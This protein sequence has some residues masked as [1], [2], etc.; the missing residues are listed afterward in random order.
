MTDLFCE[1]DQRRKDVRA[2]S[3]NGLDYLEVSDD[4]RKLTIFLLGKAPQG[5]KK[6]NVRL[7]GGR[8]VRDIQIT[9]IEWIT[10]KNPDVDDQL[11]VKVDK[12]GD[13]STYKLCMVALDEEGRPTDQPFPGFDPRYNC[14]EFSFKAGCATDLDCKTPDICPPEP[15]LEP[16][17]NYLAKDYGSFRQL[18]LDRLSVLLPDW[19]ERHVPDFGVALVELLAY[20]GDY[21]S[22]YQDAVATEAYL[23]T[24]RQRTSVRRHARLVGYRMHEG[25]NARAWVCLQ[26]GAD[27]ELKPDDFYLITGQ[28]L[29]VEGNILTPDVLTNIPLSHYEIFEP[30][31]GTPTIQLFAAHNRI[32][33]YTW[34]DG[35]KGGSCC[36]PK[37]ATTATLKDTWKFPP[38]PEPD[39]G[40][41]IQKIPPPPQET[42][43]ERELHLQPGD[44]LIFEEVL[45]PKT[46][47]PADAD[48]AHRCAVRLT[49]ITPNVDPLY[50]QPVLEIE[51]AEEDALP[52]SLCLSA[53]TNPPDCNPLE[54]VSVACG[55]VILVD[56]GRH[57]PDEDLGCVPLDHTEEQCPDPCHPAEIQYIP[58]FYRPRLAQPGLTF[59][60]PLDPLAPASSLLHQD[61]REALPWVRLL[62]S[63][64]PPC[65]PNPPITQSPNP[66]VSWL[67]QYDLLASR[68]DD[69]HFVVEMEE[70]KF[71][72][73]NSFSNNERRAHL[74]FGDGELG[75]QPAA[76]TRFTATYRV[77]NGPSGN[78]G[79]EKIT[80]FVFYNLL[81]GAALQ[82]RNPLPAQGGTA[83][84]PVAQVK[85][86]APHAFRRVLERAIIPED[87]AAIV[88]RDFPHQ[89]QR[90]AAALRWTG[91]WYEVLVA[92]DPLGNEPAD[93][94]L[95]EK[96]AGHLY[97]YRR[98]GHDLSVQPARYVPLDI[99]MIVCVQ[100]GTLRGTVKGAL[101]DVFS[102]RRRRDGT[103]GFFHPDNLTFGE[104]IFLSKLVA[105]AQVVPGV[106]SV[107]VTKL[108]RLFEGPN[109]EIENGL[110]R[111]NPMEVA[112]LDNDLGFPEN[113]KITFDLRGGR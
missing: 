60:Q 8:R 65:T 82:A 106:E 34:G 18:L 105:A 20:T 69:Y 100:P 81:S 24:A 28:D 3:F 29:P 27:R 71:P 48:P 101:L 78:V 73:D 41:N 40:S 59:S 68:P 17:I 30:L 103:P 83:P 6:E 9:S 99:E 11:V 16:D 66:P 113:G 91:S 93:P 25:C 111:L 49:R 84:E 80:H 13:Y 4:Q 104:G 63:A 90:A 75:R 109:G 21:L 70:T 39:A 5:L 44:I 96:I 97:R 52:F 12:P 7:S 94:A 26:T 76:Q 1:L 74:R 92:I 110:L 15:R 79:A 10:S 36:L 46:G 61:P 33:F 54:D 55:N 108:E 58:G 62:N 112:L 67:P 107:K 57:V 85:L 19:K 95:L 14:L 42:I 22:D 32:S 31:V 102:S 37:G 50:E 38:I 64:E 23:D 98:I 77:G 88:L 51:W 87:Y 2:S 43:P 89:V 72:H 86:F 53:T 45:G 47:N 56:H 35:A